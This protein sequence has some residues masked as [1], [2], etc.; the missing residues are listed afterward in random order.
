[1]M[2]SFKS[3]AVIFLLLL[4]INCKAQTKGSVWLHPILGFNTNWILNQN[5]YGNP[6]MDYASSF[7][8]TGGVGL[9]YFHKEDLAFDASLLISKLGQN[10]KGD[11]LGTP[12]TRGLK[13]TYIEL[14]LTVKKKISKSDDDNSTWLCLGPEIMFLTKATQDYSRIGGQPLQK[15]Q[16][17]TP[18]DIKDRIKPIDIALKFSAEKMYRLKR[19]DDMLLVVAFDSSIGLMDFNTK[20][21]QIKNIQGDYSGSHNF[22]FGIKFG[23]MFNTIL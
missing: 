17:L 3:V 16:N 10:Y 7:G 20:A 1:M 22:Y 6:E 8:L 23:V 12:A 21:W 18:G 13:F 2:K 9:C 15:P 19:T 4:A 14:P 11:Q 5:C